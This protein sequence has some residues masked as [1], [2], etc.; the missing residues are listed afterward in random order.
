[1]AQHS[2]EEQWQTQYQ[3]QQ[4]QQHRHTL[5]P[6]TSTSSAAQDPAV[7]LGQQ[8]PPRLLPSEE[9]EEEE[10]GRALSPAPQT[11]N[12]LMLQSTNINRSPYHNSP[13]TFSALYNTYFSVPPPNIKSQYHNQNDLTP[14]HAV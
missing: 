2:A 10:E 8:Q 13:Y 14:S 3:Q 7:V 6:T 1:M 12:S 9:E 5:A 4:Q 11:R